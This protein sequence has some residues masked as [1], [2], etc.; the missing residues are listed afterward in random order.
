[1]HLRMTRSTLWTVAAL[2]FFLVALAARL[3]WTIL[4][5]PGLA[6]MW[7]GALGADRADKIPVQNRTRT[8]LN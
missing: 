1:M 8:G 7:Y 4:W 5:V 2:M 6:L 3:P